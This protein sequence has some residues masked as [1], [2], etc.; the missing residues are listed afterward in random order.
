MTTLTDRYVWAA[1]RTVP[2]PQRPGLEPEIRELV[3]ESVRARVAAGE[4]MPAAE[5]RALTDLGDPERL[6]AAYVDRPLT[7]IGPRYYLDWWRL[8]RTVTLL[9]VPISAAA[10]L[11]AQLLVTNDPG[12]AI[13]SAVST[14]LGVTVHL[15]FWITLVFV[16]IERSGAPGPGAAWTPEALP[17]LPDHSRRSR[18]PDLIASLV[19]LA[20]VAGVII[21]QQLLPA[22]R[23]SAGGAVPFLDPGLW[24]FWIP[25]FL[26]L[27]AAEAVFAVVLYRRG[28]S[29]SLAAVNLGLN[30]AF[31]VPAVFL[32]AGDRLL[33]PAFPAAVGWDPGAPEAAGAL[34]GAGILAAI[35]AIVAWDVI[36]GFLKARRAGL[37][38]R[39]GRRS[40]PS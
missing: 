38:A 32:W 8:L 31:V 6:A 7:L 10:V 28:W 30:L 33:N 13:G 29:W 15:A 3:E 12:D 21:W 17:D 19:V 5:S 16:I 39:D 20:L 4:D 36:E 11:V 9:V 40:N 34:L 25:W 18:L 1:V 14:A 24:S 35:L 23:D 2:E 27:L 22:V 37:S 26:G